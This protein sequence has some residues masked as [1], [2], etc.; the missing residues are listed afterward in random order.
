MSVPIHRS[1]YPSR[2][3]R[4]KYSPRPNLSAAPPAKQSGKEILKSYF[5]KHRCFKGIPWNGRNRAALGKLTNA[6]RYARTAIRSDPDLIGAYLVLAKVDDRAGNFKKAKDQFTK[7]VQ[8]QSDSELVIKAHAHFLSGRED[9]KK[10]I[11]VLLNYLTRFPFAAEAED[12]L[13]QVYWQ[14]S[15]RN[16]ALQA[17]TNAA[18]AF[19]SLGNKFKFNAIRSGAWAAFVEKTPIGRPVVVWYLNEFSAGLHLPDRCRSL[20]AARLTVLLLK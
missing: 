7:L 20:S 10:E 9:I 5:F 18:K 8:N 1:I 17:R 6:R 13:G 2:A 14:Q 11:Q 15:L 3:I 4:R 12:L 19:H 16:D